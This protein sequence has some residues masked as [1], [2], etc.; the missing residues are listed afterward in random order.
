MIQPGMM[1]QG[2]QGGGGMMGRQS[3]QYGMVGQP[4]MMGGQPP[5]MPQPY[6]PPIP[7][8]GVHG[9]PPF[10]GPRR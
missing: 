1:P 2:M 7:Y 8:F 3:M 9:P 6:A 5:Y 4:G 10:V